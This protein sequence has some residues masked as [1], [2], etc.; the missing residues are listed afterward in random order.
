MEL[1]CR[2]A[3]FGAEAVFTTVSKASAG[4]HHDAAAIDVCDKVVLNVGVFGNDR[5][6]V[7]T[8]VLFDVV[9]GFDHVIDELDAR[10]EGEVF[11]MVVAVVQ[12]P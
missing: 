2:N 3:H 12:C 5:F 8:A 9:A 11:V 1:V 6:C 4:V 7:A 10:F